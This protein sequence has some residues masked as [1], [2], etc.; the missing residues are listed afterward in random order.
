MTGA[1][2]PDPGQNG[3]VIARIQAGCVMWSWSVFGRRRSNQPTL[4]VDDRE[5]LSS[6]DGLVL[7]LQMQPSFDQLA[8]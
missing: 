1:D 5:S 2:V 4:R 6:I 8:E 7:D 3:S